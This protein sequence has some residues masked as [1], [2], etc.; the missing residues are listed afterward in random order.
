MIPPLYRRTQFATISRSTAEELVGLGVSRPRIHPLDL[1]IDDELLGEPS[2]K[3]TE[4][5]FVVVSRLTPNKRVDRI[6][7]AW[8]EVRPQIG[9]RLVIIGDGPQM[10]DLRARGVPGVELRG[11]VAE[12]RRWRL[13][14][15]AWLLVHA[16]ANEGWGLVIM[17]AAARSTP[18]LA[19]DANGVRDAVEPGS[20]ARSSTIPPA[21]PTPGSSSSTTAP[22]SSTGPRRPGPAPSTSPGPRTTD[23]LLD[24][25]ALARGPN[26]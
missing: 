24:V 2:P 19:V 20:P 13:L 26:R 21:W 12:T 9:G 22:G 17:E 25:I 15:Q 6:L 1:G 16:A 14:D 10:Q 4:P 7:D 8:S 11:F 23:Q 5:L 3:S 18:A